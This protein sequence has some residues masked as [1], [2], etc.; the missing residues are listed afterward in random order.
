[1]GHDFEFNRAYCFSNW[2]TS[3][4]WEV[5]TATSHRRLLVFVIDNPASREKFTDPRELYYKLSP[6]RADQTVGQGSQPPVQPTEV[7][8]SQLTQ[9]G[10]REM[11]SKRP[12]SYSTMRNA[13]RFLPY[14]EGHLEPWP[15]WSGVL[16]RFLTAGQLWRVSYRLNQREGT[17]YY[18]E[19]FTG[20]Q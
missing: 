19:S 20:Q 8:S 2:Q 3:E 16:Q 9:A 10:K 15:T 4:T 5:P 17:E 1:M 12:D 11:P 6:L 7:S 14:P 13:K 18:S